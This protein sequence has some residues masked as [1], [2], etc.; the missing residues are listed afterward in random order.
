MS[1]GKLPIVPVAKASDLEGRLWISPKSRTLQP[2]DPADSRWPSREIIARAAPGLADIINRQASPRRQFAH[3]KLSGLKLDLN[4]EERAELE[5]EEA[6]MVAKLA[7]PVEKLT[8][9]KELDRHRDVLWLQE[10]P[11]PPRPSLCSLLTQGKPPRP[12]APPLAEP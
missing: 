3:V 9:K 11:L 4:A 5:V 12:K 10:V 2:D 1:A 7:R 6:R 8:R